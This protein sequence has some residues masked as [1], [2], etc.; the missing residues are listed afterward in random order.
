MVLYTTVS[1][2]L[3][4]CNFFVLEKYCGFLLFFFAFLLHLNVSDYQTTYFYRNNLRIYKILFEMK[5]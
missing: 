4:S 3:L 2:L 5:V 1:L